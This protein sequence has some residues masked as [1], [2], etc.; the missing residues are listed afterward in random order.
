MNKPID[1]S[2]DTKSKSTAK[3]PATYL[4][5]YELVERVRAYDPSV[6]E[7]LLNKAYVFSVKAHGEQTR[8]SGDPY[9]AHP[10][11]VAGILA[12]LHLDVA[13]VCTALLHDVLEDTDTTFEELATEFTQEIAELVDGVTKLGQ[14]TMPDAT[15][16]QAQA[17]NFQKFVLAMS[18]DVRVLLVKLCDRLHNMRTLHFHPKPESRQRIARETMEIYAPLARRV[19]MD[20]ICT[21]LEDW[22]FRYI[23]PNA[24]ETMER[25][26]NDWRAS[27]GEAISEIST[28][29]RNYFDEYGL[30]AR[31]YGREKRAYAI[32]RKLQRQN[33]SFDE[34]ADIYA[35]RIIVEKRKDCYDALYVLHDAYRAVPSR[36]RD[37]ISVP[38]PNGYQSL[39]TTVRTAD[40][41]RVE[42]QIRTERM[43]DIAERGVAAHWTYK[44]QSYGFD[45]ESAKAVGSDPL[46][47][48][49]PLVEMMEQSGDAG[50]FLEHAKLEMFTDQVFTF[51]PKGDLI[52]LP[53]GA[54]PLDFAYAVHTK[55]G[56]TCIGALVNGKKHPLRRPLSNGDV[57]KI[58]RGGEE[59]AAEGW[60]N[61]VVTGKARSALRRL[62]RTGEAEEFTRIGELLAKHAFAREK[63]G[64]SDAL[65][66]DAV[67]RE[68][69]QDADEMFEAL[70]RGKLSLTQFM[71]IVFP[72]RKETPVPF[73]DR[74]RDI[75][76]DSTAPLYVKGDGLRPG[77]SLHFSSCCSPI[78]G[79]RILGLQNTVDNKGGIHIH[80]ID[81]D[82]LSSTDIDPEQWLDLGW[83][84][85][86]E[87]SS[88]VGRITMT[89]EH[90]PGALADLTRI[91][92]DAGG[93][94]V[95]IKTVKRSPVFFDMVMD[96]EV[97]DNR[98]LIQIIAALRA[99]AYVIAAE[100]AHGEIIAST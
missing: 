95:N 44:D 68:N 6:D 65:M 72:A 52:A 83:R 99:S 96:V 78:P 37:F 56:D 43:E 32:W 91:I 77:V 58:I 76:E 40:N 57:V 70:G 28:S 8:H 89:V 14:V 87:Q 4:R 47:R 21:E 11:E 84:R 62:T 49:R 18:K 45:P 13:T 34:V 66:R 24:F 26:L 27:Q 16:E 64:F 29:L 33:I 79:D 82:V 31:I 74:Q 94:M 54:M 60:E 20:R 61:L 55:I 42:I 81:C 80:T 36:F 1:I 23:N 35:F 50:E 46:K 63:L 69:M 86:A 7:A 75:I 100:R 17:E 22:S 97:R 48:I 19:G 39:H 3:K 85:S 67:K 12:D 59:E 10:I 98:H 73:K 38:K 15:K 71:E 9:Y 51:T 5:Q 2:A 92:G 93:N 25:R 88:A 30:K 41:R 53:R 90:V